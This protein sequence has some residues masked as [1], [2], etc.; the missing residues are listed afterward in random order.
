MID[1]KNN[2]VTGNEL[3]GAKRKSPLPDIPSKTNDKGVSDAEGQF[4]YTHLNLFVIVNHLAFQS[5]VQTRR[6]N[7]MTNKPKALELVDAVLQSKAL[8]LMVQVLD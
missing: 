1:K 7:L 4:L 6:R 2:S 3:T 5:H 8:E